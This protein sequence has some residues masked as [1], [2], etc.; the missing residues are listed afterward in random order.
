MLLWWW[1]LLGLHLWL[2]GWQRRELVGLEMLLLLLRYGSWGWQVG[3]RLL[4][5]TRSVERWLLLRRG[6]R[7]VVMINVV[8]AI[9]LVVVI[10]FGRQE[11]R[12]V[13]AWLK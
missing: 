10:A 5:G 1:G 11:G 7:F 13:H 3:W 12:A 2:L 8:S 9:V 4:V 6:D